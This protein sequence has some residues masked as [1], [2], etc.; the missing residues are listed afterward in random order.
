MTLADPA[1]QRRRLVRGGIE[2]RSIGGRAIE[3]LLRITP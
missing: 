1:T 2:E 3:V